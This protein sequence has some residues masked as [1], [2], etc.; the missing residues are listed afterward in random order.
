MNIKPIILPPTADLLEPKLTRKFTSLSNLIF[1]AG[2]HSLPDEL[3]NQINKQIDE[4]AQTPDSTEETLKKL[5]AFQKDL[6]Q[7]L[8]SDFRLLP[9]NYHR[10]QW[11]SLGMASFGIPI[12][13]FFGLATDNL[14]LLAIGLPIGMSIGMV[15]GTSMDQKVKNEGR[16]LDFHYS[17]L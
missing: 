4:I 11:M 9:K 15:M 6:L 17:R 8:K 7:K 10:N 3:V 2:K 1:E 13:L 5:D 12:G 16:Q 14:G